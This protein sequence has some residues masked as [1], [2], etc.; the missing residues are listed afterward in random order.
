ML[1]PYK[2][3]FCAPCADFLARKALC[4]AESSTVLSKYPPAGCQQVAAMEY[5]PTPALHS[6]MPAGT[7]L[8]V[9]GAA[10]RCGIL[11]LTPQCC[12]VL[13]GQ[14]PQLEQARQRMVAHWSQPA[15]KLKCRPC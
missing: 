13:G 12:A 1:G 6:A 15:G 14:V 10:V 4:H 9:H 11:L 3:S 2:Q 7:K 8:V 5:R